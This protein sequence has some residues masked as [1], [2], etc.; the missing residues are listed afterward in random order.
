MRLKAHVA[1]VHEEGS[2]SAQPLGRQV[3]QVRLGDHSVV[4]M[5]RP[6]QTRRK[7]RNCVIYTWSHV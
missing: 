2:V 7:S 5:E 6:L 3:E 4:Q 1:T